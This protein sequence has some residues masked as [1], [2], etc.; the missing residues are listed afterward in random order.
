MEEAKNL[1]K[2]NELI[3]ARTIYQQVLTQLSDINQI[4]Q[5]KAKIENL[6]IRILFSPLVDEDSFL[7]EVKPGDTL[8]KIAR[9]FNTTVGLL[10][11]SNN[12]KNDIIKVGQK[13][14]VIK[15]QFSVLVDKSQNKLFLKEGDKIIKAYVVSTGKGGC[16]PVGEFK[17]VNKLKNPVWFRKDVGAVVPAK[18]PKNVLGSRWMGI[19]M[20][21][22]GIHGT[23]H[24]EELG[25]SVTRG[26]IRM[27]NKDVEEL[28]DIL[29][30]GAKVTI[31]E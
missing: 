6:N 7:Y 24:P 20:P 23:I 30:K 13:L 31:M 10:K 25:K 18:S 21:G 27:R 4:K 16:T 2:N 14:K 8:G 15:A 12:L 29:P 28:Y 5:I 19:S 11:R 17:I 3:K 9:R 22:Y 1:E 26:C